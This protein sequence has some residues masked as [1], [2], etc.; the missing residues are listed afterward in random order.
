MRSLLLIGCLFSMAAFAAVPTTSSD[1]G[2]VAAAGSTSTAN[3]I[4]TVGA[5]GADVWGKADEFRF[6][7]GTLNGDGE[8][9]ARVDSLTATNTWTKAGV[10]IRASLA[11]NSPNAYALVSSGNGMVFQYRPSSGAVTAQEGAANRTRAPYWVRVRRVGNVLTAYSSADGQNWQQQGGAVSISM[12]ANVYAG[13]AVTSHLD[14]TLATAK[15]SNVNI[16]SVG[17]A[18][19][20]TNTPPKITGTPPTTATVGTQYVFTPTGTDSDGN[21]LRYNIVNR[22]NWATFNTGTG[23][24]AGTPAS[25]NVGTYPNIQIS[26]SDGRASAQLPAFSIVV[27]NAPTSNLAPVISGTP[28]ASAVAGVAYLFQ[29]SASDANGDRLTFSISNVPSW[30]SFDTAT[31]RLQ[32]T[33]TAS[34]LGTYSNVSITV[35][36]GRAT[37]A[38]TPFSITVRAATTGSATLSWTPPTTNADGSTLTNL[39][40][41]RIYWGT[42]QGDYSSSVTVNNP[43]LS[44]YVVDNLLPGTY[45]FAV[46]ARNSAGVEGGMSNTASKTIR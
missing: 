2:G 35:S 26:V 10:M 44:S 27:S 24:L 37:S 43:G 4:Y 16:G 14:G 29:P 25:S 18:P 34:H 1:I 33:P 13:L 42:S 32:G 3:G 38:L 9:T 11:A 30:A 7:Y 17:A 45:Y 6:V 21:Q 40:G 20:S 15:F 23:R 28:S 12:Q 41:Y 46:S 8:I 22:P 39:A 5:S 31:G 19:T 36:D